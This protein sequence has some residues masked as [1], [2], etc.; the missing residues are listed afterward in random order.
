MLIDDLHLADSYQLWTLFGP[1]TRDRKGPQQTGPKHEIKGLGFSGTP[2]ESRNQLEV[3]VRASWC[4]RFK[5]A[6]V[7]E[8]AD[9]YA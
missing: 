1:Y 5:L 4:D 7:S 6:V 3:G 9:A 8:L 2:Q